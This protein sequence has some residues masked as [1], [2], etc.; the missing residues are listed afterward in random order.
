[1][2]KFLSDNRETGQAE[3]V[4]NNPA[5]DESAINVVASLFDVLIE[6]DQDIKLI[7]KEQCNDAS[8]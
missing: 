5:L 1:M 6:I 3:I 7:K 8:V 2:D 4:G